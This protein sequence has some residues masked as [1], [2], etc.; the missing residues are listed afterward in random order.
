MTR[1]PKCQALKWKQK[2][3]LQ[4]C[5]WI[6]TAVRFVLV[7]QSAAPCKH[8]HEILKMCT[9]NVEV[10]LEFLANEQIIRTSE[11]MPDAS[12]FP[13]IA[14]NSKQGVF[15]LLPNSCLYYCLKIMRLSTDK[16][17]LCLELKTCKYMCMLLI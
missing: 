3:C 14:T 13:G 1:N 9:A 2:S 5:G 17:L 7:E 4:A 15:D 12:Q 11:V 8:L 16:M 10:V 6:S